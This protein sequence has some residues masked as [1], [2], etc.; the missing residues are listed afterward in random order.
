MNKTYFLTIITI[1]KCVGLFY[2]PIR[3]HYTTLFRTLHVF[4]IALFYA[5]TKIK[6][7]FILFANFVT[8]VP[9]INARIVLTFVYV[10]E[11]HRT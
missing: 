7:G 4:N 10:L 11:R 8:L 6:V 9:R 1:N 2:L 3:H 5:N